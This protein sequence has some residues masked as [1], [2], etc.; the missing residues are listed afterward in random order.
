MYINI[1]I[2]CSWVLRHFLYRQKSVYRSSNSPTTNAANLRRLTFSE[3][4]CQD[5]ATSQHQHI[6]HFIT[7]MHPP[8]CLQHYYHCPQCTTRLNNTTNT[9]LTRG[10]HVKHWTPTGLRCTEFPQVDTDGSTETLHI[11]TTVPSLL[12]HRHVLLLQ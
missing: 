2:L 12:S 11:V 5:P 4:V 6:N 1:L 8:I 3:D 7:L 9:N 10:A